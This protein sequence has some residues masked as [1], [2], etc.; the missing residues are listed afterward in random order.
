MDKEQSYKQYKLNGL[1]DSK[2]LYMQKHHDYKIGTIVEHFKQHF[3]IS[4][5]EFDKFSEKFSDIPIIKAKFNNARK[6]AFG[7]D[8]INFYDWF[9]SQN[10]CCGYCGITQ[11]ELHTLFTNNSNTKKLPLNDNWSKNDK[12]TLQIERLDSKDN[13]YVQS[14]I[15]LAC[16][17]CNNAKSNL[18]DEVSWRDIFVDSMREYYEK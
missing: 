13:S 6:E 3:E 1:L 16:P 4:Q 18:I 12:G 15:I 17:L 14:N 7:N 11:E 2:E 8:A 5:N 10:D 9:K